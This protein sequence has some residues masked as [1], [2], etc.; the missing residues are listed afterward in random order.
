MEFFPFGGRHTT[1]TLELRALEVNGLVKRTV[2]DTYPIK[3]TYA[4]TAHSKSLEEVIESL[5]KWGTLYR[6]KIMHQ[7]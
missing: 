4:L 5:R 3:V 7:E 2:H 6:K 1:V